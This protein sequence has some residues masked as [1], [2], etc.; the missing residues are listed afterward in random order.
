[1]D[2]KLLNEISSQNYS[3]NNQQGHEEFNREY[4]NFLYYGPSQT[5]IRMISNMVN[6][7]NIPKDPKENLL[8]HIVLQI[9]DETALNEIQIACWS[10]INDKFVWNNRAKDI[11]MDLICSALIV[12]ER[13]EENVE[14]LIAKYSEK[15]ESFWDYYQKWAFTVRFFKLDI[16]EVNLKYETLSKGKRVKINYNYYLENVFLGYSPYNHENRLQKLNEVVE[17]KEKNSWK[18]GII[19]PTQILDEVYPE[20]PEEFDIFSFCPPPLVNRSSQEYFS[21]IGKYI[22]SSSY[23]NES[24]AN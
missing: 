9:L 6:A 17:I 22:Y 21:S 10:V 19:F 16:K 14:Y 23:S 13:M 3:N 1:M 12:K 11:R 20:I 4:S 2:K 8:Q 18:V 7:P 15:N 5:S 24:F